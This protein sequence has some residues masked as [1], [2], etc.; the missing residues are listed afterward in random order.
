MKKL[1]NGLFA[2]GLMI[3][4]APSLAA[5]CGACIRIAQL[6]KDAGI[7]KH[8]L[9]LAGW[10]PN[11]QGKYVCYSCA[12]SVKAHQYKEGDD[13]SSDVFCEETGF[14]EA[15]AV[16]VSDGLFPYPEN[17]LLRSLCKLIFG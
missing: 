15:D 5:D 4:T 12:H 6:Q 7:C 16:E 14:E 2:L 8:T 13:L 17:V 10:I 1:L 11:A 9:G 3:A